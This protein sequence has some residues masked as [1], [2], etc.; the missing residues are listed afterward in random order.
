LAYGTDLHM[1]HV[2]QKKDDKDKDT[3]DT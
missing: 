2:N 3:P 1:D